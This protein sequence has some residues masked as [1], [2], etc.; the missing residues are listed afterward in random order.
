M[1]PRAHARRSCSTTCS[2]RGR[3]SGTPP[4]DTVR[5]APTADALHRPRVEPRRRGGVDRRRRRPARRGPRAARA[6]LASGTDGEDEVRTYGHIVVDEA[7]DLSPMQLRM[8]ARRSL[9]GSMT[10]VGDIAQATGTVGH[11]ETGRTSSPTCPTAV[12]TPPHR[13]DRRLPHP[14]PTWRWPRGCCGAGAP[15]LTPPLGRAPRRGPA[16]DRPGPGRRPVCR[17]EVVA[18][19][20]A[21][22]RPRRAGNVA[23]IVPP[24]LVEA[25]AA[26]FDGRG[27]AFGRATRHGLDAA[28]PSCRSAWSRAWSSTPSWWS[29]RPPSSPRSRRACGRCTSPSPGP[30]RRLAVVH[31]RPLPDPM[32]EPATAA[33]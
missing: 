13:A 25:V 2:A 19:A 12:A 18:A 15:W 27:V 22:P 1:W 17:A 9:N 3:C 28:S 5:R 23:V 21:G 24:S 7:Q 32:R 8:L 6:R 4:G 16:R 20:V 11:A 14:G 10:I 33:A 30:P 31:A 26:G 29:S